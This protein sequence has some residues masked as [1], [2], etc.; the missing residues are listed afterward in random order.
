[1]PRQLAA[2]PKAGSLCRSSV[3]RYPVFTFAL[4]GLPVQLETAGLL[5]DVF[6][7]SH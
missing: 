7:S 5:D 3:E 2:G 4:R 1:M 6:L